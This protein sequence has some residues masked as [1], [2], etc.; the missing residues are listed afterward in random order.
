LNTLV[1][2]TFLRIRKTDRKLSSGGI[3][4]LILAVSDVSFNLYYALGFVLR[5]LKEQDQDRDK[6]YPTF[7]VTHGAYAVVSGFVNRYLTLFITVTRAR[8]LFSF[9]QAHRSLEK[10]EGNHIRE[11]ICFGVLPMAIL[12]VGLGIQE[13]IEGVAPFKNITVSEFFRD[14]QDSISAIVPFSSLLCAEVAMVLLAAYIV[15]KARRLELDEA[16]KTMQQNVAAVALV[17]CLT[18]APYL[19]QH[20]EMVFRSEKLTINDTFMKSEVSHFFLALGSVA[21]IFIYVLVGEKFPKTLLSLFTECR[22]KWT[23]RREGQMVP[24]RGLPRR[25]VAETKL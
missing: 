14:R 20:A 19:I 21:N 25:E 15:L 9:R 10:T 11:T 3:H 2:A 12:S 18:Q 17:Y 16:S 13:I 5:L 24:T 8:V 4:L 7:H 22:Q 23:G 1:I 6:E